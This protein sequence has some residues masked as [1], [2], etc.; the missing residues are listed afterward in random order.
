MGHAATDHDALDVV[1]HDQRVDR[2]G[3][4]S[5]DVIDQVDRG[6]V[7]APRQLVDLLRG[8]RAKAQRD[9]WTGGECLEAAVLPALA[10][11]PTKLDDRVP[12]LP[13][14]TAGAAVE[15]SVEHDARRDAGAD[16]E[17]GES[18]GRHR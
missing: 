12:D 6:L 15:L 18:F 13:G 14:E 1:G 2:P 9:R 10:A 5:P 3:E 11:R 7:A 17:V 4:P 16:R 8:G